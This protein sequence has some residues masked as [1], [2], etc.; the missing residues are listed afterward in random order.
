MIGRCVFNDGSAGCDP[1]A[2]EFKSMVVEVM[3]LAGVFNIGDFIPALEFL[4]LQGVQAKMKKLHKRFDEFLTSIIE[5][6][7]ACKSEKHNDMLSTLL[8]LKDVPDDEGT[9]LTDTE[10]KAL[11]LNLFTAGTDTSSSTTEWAIAELIRHPRMLAQVQQE[12]N[13]VVG[14][15]RL[16]TELDLPNL[17]YLQAVVKETFRL[18]P[19][20]P[21]SLPRMA[22]KSCEEWSDPLEFNPERFLPGGEK[23]DE[24]VRGNDFEVIPFGAGRRICAAPLIVHPWPRLSPQAY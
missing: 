3:V 22:D 20:T 24:D 6:H 4:D 21:L 11:L 15:D 16:V 10:I 17:P 19:S 5:E 9:R 23:A 13:A 18:H 7:K 1:R 12:I 14:R 8:S 2:D